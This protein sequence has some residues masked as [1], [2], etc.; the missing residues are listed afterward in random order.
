[1]SRAKVVGIIGGIGPYAGLDLFKKILDNTNANTDIEHIPLILYSIPQEIDDRNDFILG[2]SNSNP[3]YS[4]S[5]I[6][7]KLKKI[8]AEIIAI[9]CNNAHASSIF[10]IIKNNP[11]FKSINVLSIVDALINYLDSN[12]PKVKNI[13]IMSVKGAY[14][15]KVYDNALTKNNFNV[16]DLPEELQNLVNEAI[17]NPKF[18]IKAMSTPVSKKAI[19]LLNEIMQFF[20]NKNAEVIILACTELPLAITDKYVSSTIILDATDIFAQN[21]IKNSIADY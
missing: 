11:E 20:V 10:D 14:I 15:S 13:G 4:I 12:L 5:N 3:A 7:L 21:I 18:G 2:K 9:A 16:I 1:M 19:G 6:I 8:G 17:W